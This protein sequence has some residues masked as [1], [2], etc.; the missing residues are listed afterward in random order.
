MISFARFSDFEEIHIDSVD[1][2]AMFEPKNL[3]LDC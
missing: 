2:F 1:S 3:T